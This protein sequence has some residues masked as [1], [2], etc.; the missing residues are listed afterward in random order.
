LSDAI[1]KR[2]NDWLFNHALPF[3][4]ANGVDEQFGGAVEEL[5]LDVGP[6]D[7]GF[8]RVRVTCRQIYVWSNAYVLGWKPGLELAKAHYEV[9]AKSAW[10]G[11]DKGWARLL[12]NDNNIL[13]R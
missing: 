2:I 8:K 10:Q 13:D 6:S 7:P 12:N 4:A 1:P 11:R 9:L 3:W 5:S